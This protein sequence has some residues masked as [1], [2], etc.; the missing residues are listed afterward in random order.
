MHEVQFR[1]YS[2]SNGLPR[3]G[4]GQ[5]EGHGNIGWEIL[6]QMSLIDEIR[7]KFARDEFEFS[8]HAVDQTVRRGISVAEIRQAIAAGAVIEDY[9]DDK[10]GPSCLI[11]GRTLA[12]RPLHLQTSYPSRSIVKIITL[13]EPDPNQWINY[14]RRK[15]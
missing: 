13:Y 7:A 12:G 9:P 4:H 2:L 1:L 15:S 3:I 14:R 8:R 11:F 5:M 6:E 10:Y